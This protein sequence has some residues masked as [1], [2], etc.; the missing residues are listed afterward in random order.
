MD[1]GII[2]LEGV[3]DEVFNSENSRMQEFLGKLKHE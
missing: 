3:P 2:A 1:K